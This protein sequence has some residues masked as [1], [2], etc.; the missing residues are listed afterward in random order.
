MFGPLKGSCKAE[1]E[2]KITGAD[3]I[4]FCHV[5]LTSGLTHCG[6][7][8]HPCQ[9]DVPAHM[10][11]HDVRTSPTRTDMHVQRRGDKMRACRA[12][13]AQVTHTYAVLCP[14]RC[15]LGICVFHHFHI[16][17]REPLQGFTQ[18][19]LIPC[20]KHHLPYTQ[21]STKSHTCARVETTIK[22]CRNAPVR[23]H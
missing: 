21:H 3:I 14:D 6:P 12:R 1:G 2:E 11:R 4:C 18:L 19:D 13:G 9:A 16:I 5:D 17:P 15:M 22:Q 7:V 10:L 23:P 20:T 8:L